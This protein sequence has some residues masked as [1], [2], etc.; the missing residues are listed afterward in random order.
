MGLT[1]SSNGRFFTRD[2][3]PFF[4]LGDTAWLLFHR[5]SLA[6]TK[7]YLTNR[8]QKGFT[9]IQATLVHE[10]NAK[11]K[12]GFPALLDEDFSRPNPDTNLDSYW[13]QVEK[14]ICIADE[15]GLV[16]ALLPAWGSFYK[17]GALNS[18]NAEAYT[19]F[20]ASRFGRY[21]NLIWLV[22]GDVRG[23]VAM[24]SIRAVGSA[25]RAKC[26]N[27]LI[28][29]HPFG[30]CS[31]SMWFHQDSWLDFNMFQSGHR[32]YTQ[33][34]LN[35]WDDNV[36]VERWVGED[37]YR[38]VQQDLA[39]T[40]AKPTL[41]GEPSYELIPQGLHDSNQPYWQAADVR[42]YAYWSMLAGSAGH[43]YG[44]N[45]IMQFWSGQGKASYGAIH[46]WQEALHNPGSMQMGHLKRLMALLPWHQGRPAQELIANNN[47]KQ[48][49]Y[50]LAMAT[51][52]AACVYAY[53]GQ[54][55][56]LDTTKLPF[57]EGHV[58]WFDPVIGGLSYAGI[59][60]NTHCGQ[61]QPP[62]RRSGQEDWILLI[63]K[64]KPDVTWV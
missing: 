7:T 55:F 38:Y 53:E 8:A 54:T 63:C 11:N 62:L 45:A 58:Y 19:D 56:C 21:A 37:N 31:S 9:V 35:T 40:P 18:G 6:D 12:L 48:H 25:L 57:T 50:L 61:F 32:N 14:T 20:L 10:P 16:M 5:L 64:D 22:G 60:D 49:K 51:P 23:N 2:G 42:R 30:R 4:W 39:L 26:P 33:L 15:L 43:T 1:I 24:E 36:D 44:D 34:K 3:Q 47:G 46:T 13:A 41:D 17:S 52:S 59:F 29:Y 28:G 27:H